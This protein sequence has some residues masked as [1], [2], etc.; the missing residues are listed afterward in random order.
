MKIAGFNFTKINAMKTGEKAENINVK[1]NVN[2]SESKE[3][4]A[5]QFKCKEQ[6]L[7]VKFNYSIVYEPKYAQLD[8]AGNVVIALDS[9]KAKQVLKEWE[10]K[11]VSQEIQLPL[12][13]MIIRK[14]N[15]KALDLEDEIGLPLY[16]PMPK[17][18]NKKK[19]E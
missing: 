10:N 15:V 4:K 14:S 17:L 9:K 12:F 3:L 6:F 16:P 13:N 11:K 18:S 5:E 1:T 19:S 7:S 2:I 8:F